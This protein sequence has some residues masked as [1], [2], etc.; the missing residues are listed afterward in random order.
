MLEGLAI[1]ALF[2]F[3]ALGASRAAS[4]VPTDSFAP[5][6]DGAPADFDALF[7]KY[8]SAYGVPWLWLKAFAM[9]ESSLGRAPSVA[10]GLVEPT[11]IEGSVSMDGKSWGLMQVTLSTAGDFDSNVT[12]ELLNDPE[13]SVSIAA[14]YIAHLIG[15]FPIV[16]PGH[17]EWVVKAYNQGQGNTQKEINGQ[18]GGYADAYWD[19]WQRNYAQIGG[20]L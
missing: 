18:G 12:P 13:Y 1:L 3:I 17:V 6:P 5:T 8:G 20:T 14:Q 11:D 15:V 9:N 19:R 7:Q 2:G 4:I 10:R 16:M